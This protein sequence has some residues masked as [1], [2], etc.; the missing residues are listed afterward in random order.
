MN[1]DG[2]KWVRMCMMLANVMHVRF[3]IRPFRDFVESGM[4][5]AE[6]SSGLGQPKLPGS[7]AQYGS[8]VEKAAENLVTS[9][10]E[11]YGLVVDP[12]FRVGS[13]EELEAKYVFAYGLGGA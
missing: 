5:S 12:P 11:R 4:W 8:T 10:I 6:F 1:G 3:D 7:Y 13:I 9:Y 2:Q